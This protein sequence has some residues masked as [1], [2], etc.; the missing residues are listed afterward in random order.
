MSTTN[1]P[2]ICCHLLSAYIPLVAIPNQDVAKSRPDPAA[3]PA[4]PLSASIRKGG[5][6][7]DG[8]FCWRLPVTHCR[9]WRHKTF[10]LLL[11]LLLGIF[12]FQKDLDERDEWSMPVAQRSPEDQP[13]PSTKVTAI[14]WFTIIAGRWLKG[15]ELKDLSYFHVLVPCGRA[16]CRDVS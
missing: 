10:R 13:K 12:F 4:V 2:L 15:V 11:H 14:A 8:S 3:A 1:F 6:M 7:D 16:T 5:M 9:W